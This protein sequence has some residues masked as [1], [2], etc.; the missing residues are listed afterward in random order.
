MSARIKI[1]SRLQ[2]LRTWLAEYA[3]YVQE[4]QAHLDNPSVAR[5]YWHYG[6]AVAL[7]DVLDLLR[8]ERAPAP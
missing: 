4:E 6:Y 3:P 2:D 8:A 1:E 5:S 7:R